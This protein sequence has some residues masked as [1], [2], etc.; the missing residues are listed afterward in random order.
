MVTHK[1]LC[2]QSYQAMVP[3]DSQLRIVDVVDIYL[4]RILEFV[5]RRLIFVVNFKHQLCFTVHLYL[6]YLT[7]FCDFAQGHHWTSVL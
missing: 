1:Q 4:W 2:I 7:S 3:S 5:C 6:L